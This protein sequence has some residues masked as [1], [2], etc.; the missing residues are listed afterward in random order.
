MRYVTTA[1]R[2]DMEK[3]M[4]KGMLSEAREMLSF[5]HFI[6]KLYF[7]GIQLNEKLICT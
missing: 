2:I 3:G 5:K 7:Y 6:T 4:E 1:E